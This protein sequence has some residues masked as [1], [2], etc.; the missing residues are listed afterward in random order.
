MA[1]SVGAVFGE[2]VKDEAHGGEAGVEQEQGSVGCAW[3]RALDHVR[4]GGKGRVQAS[5]G[6]LHYSGGT[7]AEQVDQCDAATDEMLRQE[8]AA[9]CHHHREGCPEKANACE[10]CDGRPT[11]GGGVGKQCQQAGDHQGVAAEDQPF[12]GAEDTV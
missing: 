4:A 10:Q 1:W 11:G 8:G 6:D 2:G 3:R 9:M 7:D 5:G 12:A